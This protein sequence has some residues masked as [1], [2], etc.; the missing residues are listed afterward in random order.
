MKQKL[1]HPDSAAD[2]DQPVA[3]SIAALYRREKA[4]AGRSLAAEQLARFGDSGRDQ[5]AALA[6]DWP[7]YSAARKDAPATFAAESRF[8]DHLDDQYRKV[9][10]WV[11]EFWW[12]GRRSICEREFR[13]RAARA[14]SAH[15]V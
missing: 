10:A 4:G 6:D 8:R 13:A 15:A 2:R 9:E 7:G 14:R 3:G 12:P 5:V 1:E 11:S